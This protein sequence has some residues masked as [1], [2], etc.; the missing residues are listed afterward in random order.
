MRV[1]DAGWSWLGFQRWRELRLGE[2]IKPWSNVRSVRTSKD[3]KSF[4]TSERDKQSG[5]EQGT[6][7][8]RDQNH[9]LS[10][11]GDWIGHR[12][13]V[14]ASQPF[15]KT[16]SRLHLQ[17]SDTRISTKNTELPPSRRSA[18]RY[19]TKLFGILVVE[20]S[21][22]DF[23]RVQECPTQPYPFQSRRY[24][25]PLLLLCTSRIS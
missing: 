14:E 17:K 4:I 3:E 16:P 21:M 22:P 18:S 13:S 10:T 2:S 8:R 5:P 15:W 6:N 1:L 11:A 19:F 20:I 24:W 7:W 23:R 12:C 9:C 25:K